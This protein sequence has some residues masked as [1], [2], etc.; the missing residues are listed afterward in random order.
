[1]LLKAAIASNVAS[2]HH[3]KSAVLLA[4]KY[5]SAGVRRAPNLGQGNGPINHLHWSKFEPPIDD[6]ISLRV[7]AVSGEN[8]EPVEVGVVQLEIDLPE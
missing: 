6:P 8:D 1:M 4:I 2:G 5:V 7:D 3:V